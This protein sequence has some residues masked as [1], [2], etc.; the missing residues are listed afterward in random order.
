MIRSLVKKKNKMPGIK[1]TA[2]EQL[3]E[4]AISEQRFLKYKTEL[5]VY[6]ASDDRFRQYLPNG[7]YHQWNAAEGGGE[8]LTNRARVKVNNVEADDTVSLEDR[9]RDL[10]LFLSLIAKTVTE[11]H[12]AWVMENSISLQSIY[13][14]LRT[15]YN[16]QSK[17]IHFLNVLDLKFDSS[18]MKPIGFY[19]NYRTIIMNNLAK[20]GDTISYKGPHHRQPKE[21]IGPTFED[22]IFLEVLRLIDNRLPGYI[23]Q[24]YAHKLDQTKRLMD[25]KSDIL[26][27]IE[28]FQA[29]LAEKEQLS[30]FQAT[31]TEQLALLQ[32][33]PTNLGAFNAQRS[34]HRGGNG[35][36]TWGSGRGGNNSAG[37]GRGNTAQPTKETG[38]SNWSAIHC[39]DCWWY[40]KTHMTG[41]KAC[42]CPP[43][44][45]NK[46]METCPAEWELYGGQLVQLQQAPEQEH[47]PSNTSENSILAQVTI[48]EPHN[49]ISNY[50]AEQPHLSTIVP[51]PSQILT[52][53]QEPNHSSPAHLNMDS[54][55]NV[56]F[57]RSDECHKRGFKILPNA[58]LSTLG[59]GDGKLGSIGEIDVTLYR[60]DWSVRY[61]AL[62]VP[63]LI[64]PLIAGT[65][66]M[67]D[68]DVVQFICKGTITLHGGKHTVMN[69][70]REAIMNISPQAHTPKKKSTHLAHMDTG[71]RTLLSGQ[72]LKI[73]TQMEEGELVM[74]EP[75]YTNSID[76]PGAHLS[77]VN[78]GYLEVPNNTPDPI[79]I[80]K[81]GQISTLKISRTE[82][83]TPSLASPAYYKFS[84]IE[85]EPP[86]PSKGIQNLDKISWGPTVDKDIRQLLTAEHIKHAAVFDESLKEGYNGYFGKY[87]CK[88]NWAGEERPKANKLRVVNY[89]HA[90]NGLLQQVMD[91][92]THQNVLADPQEMHNIQVHTICPSFLKRKRKAKDKPKELL[93]KDDVRLL[94]NFGPVNDLI[95][96][97]PAPLTTVDDVFNTLGKFKHIIM[98]DLYNGFFQNHMAQSSL[99]WLGI[100]TPF[101]G[102]RVITRSAQGLLGMSEE[103]TLLI[104]KII[105]EELQAGKCVQLV[106]DIIVG[107]KTQQEAMENYLVILHKF[108]LANI[109]ISAAKTHIFPKS[110]DVMG[111]LWHQ[112]G[113]L[114]PSPHRRNALANTKQ[115]DI[116]KVRDMRSF[117]GLYNTLRRATPDISTLL[118]PLIQAVADK[119]SK[120]TF[121]WTHELEMKFR[122]AKSAIENMHTLY[123]PSPEDRLAMVPDGARMTP[124]IGHV[125]YAI[126]DDTKIPVRY[127]S[128]KLPD[129]CTKWSP[130]EVEALSFATGIE[131]EY[132]LIRESKHPLLIC[133]DNKAVKDAVELIKKGKFSAS[134]RINRFITNVNKV[135]LEVV[136]ISGKANLN[137]VADYQS[138]QPSC[139]TSEIC[140]ICRFVGDMVDTVLDPA[141]KNAAVEVEAPIPVTMTNKA[142]WRA[143][144]K[145]CSAC[146]SAYNLLKSG[147]VPP[148][149]T[150]ELFCNIRDY[151][152]E[153]TISSDKLLVV[154]TP[155]NQLTGNITRQRIVVPQKLLPMVLHQMHT[156]TAN[157]PTKSQL[158]I[159]FQRS[160]YAIGLDK[161]LEELYSNCYSCSL[162]QRLPK[163][164]VANESKA[165][166]S[167]PHQYFHID[168]IQRAGQKILLLTDH[169]SSFQT[170]KLIQSEKATDL[171][172]GMIVLTEALRHPGPITVKP[173]NAK[174]FASLAKGDQDLLNL[175]ITLELSDP[176]NKNSNAVIDRACQEL[177]E[178]LRKL[179]PEGKPINQATL[180]RAVLLVNQKIRRGGSLSAYE[181]HTSRDLN[182]GA[183]LN[184]DDQAIRE[185]Q[186]EKRRAGPNL[187]PS[188][189]KPAI[190]VGDTVTVVGAQNKHTAREAFVVTGTRGGRVQAQK[191]LHPLDPGKVKL[192]SK[193]YDTDPKRLIA[194]NQPWRT[195]PPTPTQPESRR[196]TIVQ[197]PPLSDSDSDSEDDE[198]EAEIGNEE[199]RSEST[200]EEQEDIEQE[201]EVEIEQEEQQLESDDMD[202]EEVEPDM[203]DEGN[204]QDTNDEEDHHSTD[205]DDGDQEEEEHDAD[206]ED[207]GEQIEGEPYLDQHRQPRKGDIVSFREG[208]EEG[209]W[210]EAKITS[211]CT[212]RWRYYYNVVTEDTGE[213][214]GIWLK[215]PQITDSGNQ[216]AWHLGRRQ[217]FMRSPVRPPSRRVSFGS[218]VRSESR[219]EASILDLS[220][221]E[222]IQLVN[223]SI[224]GDRC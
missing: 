176:L 127:H 44:A 181:L 184:L 54:G 5:E 35:G 31:T 68:N 118:D 224:S 43:E 74:V 72:T 36:R 195:R 7:A 110:A 183:N 139:C 200:E 45:I 185:N 126:K 119:D 25:F 32:V 8:R 117:I 131:A 58:Q 192:M 197:T 206:V 193:I 47:Q 218:M 216:E 94:I 28:R 41:D 130:C 10:A 89:D 85:T 164:A 102:L 4:G 168:V 170:A 80:G 46:F 55:A 149:K 199:Q 73:K 143:A 52:V 96:D 150:G 178:E 33:E 191:L 147:K 16:I 67:K 133:P 105:K 17:G 144:Q 22:F 95:K 60:N 106:D 212:G 125:L 201:Q 11:N 179:S 114:E 108:S 180:A 121:V 93:T 27:N 187:P 196:S 115:E 18:T 91:D 198:Q 124:G 76:W 23:R 128:L 140:S 109:K 71:L 14:T 160:F 19:N 157:H 62:V 166:V 98:F 66:F 84:K 81:K 101:G 154:K 214:Y 209:H 26:V 163:T 51:E 123:L 116:Q 113:K 223:G 190:K 202:D 122:E 210:V 205:E 171:K 69:T 13:D 172:D 38:S 162:L 87:E 208:G 70:R 21:I 159:T 39:K 112:G 204:Q 141:A 153:A 173:D 86:Q 215:P 24:L 37:R 213:K 82:N 40:A 221:A 92:L 186:L 135:P 146:K 132:D 50:V 34:N 134:S 138:R 104:R 64:H 97:V 15:D 42:P 90:L 48:E 120:D 6:L 203:S 194:V 53:Y 56:S 29:E 83:F 219:D 111:W 165:E 211:A 75:W 57:I 151:C 222:L 1:I 9:N 189:P 12:Y 156:S 182:S 59:D 152:R 142:S 3:P 61:R 65:T 63:K 107:G 78:H 177:E 169:F 148:S 217:D 88:L 145:Q 155:P 220:P 103:F 129:N 79:L 100:M 175:G 167:H 136:H 188:P 137:E 30:S 158:K 99:P 20:D 207:N 77:Q 161:H 174:G 2:P 49:Q